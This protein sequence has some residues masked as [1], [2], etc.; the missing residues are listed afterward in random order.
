VEEEP[1]VRRRPASPL[2]S[3]QRHP[4]RTVSVVLEDQEVKEGDA[5]QR[6]MLHPGGDPT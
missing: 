2:V 5:G 3:L 6:W 1:R 4:N